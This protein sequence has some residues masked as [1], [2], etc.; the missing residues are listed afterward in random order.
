MANQGNHSVNNKREDFK[1]YLNEF[2]VIDAL[3]NVLADLNGLEIRPTDPLDYIRTHMTEIVKEKEELKIL[4]ANY[5]S[6]ISQIQEMEEEI[7]K[8]SKKIKVLENYGDES[9]RSK[10]EETDEINIGTE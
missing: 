6:M 7:M 5:E 4:K 2:G 8:L 3:T 10:I 1:K 9:S